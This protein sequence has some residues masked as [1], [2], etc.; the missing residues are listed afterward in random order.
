VIDTSALID[1]ERGGTEWVDRLGDLGEETVALPAIVYG[2]PM[3]G[4]TMAG[5]TRRAERR[6]AKVDALVTAVGVVPFDQE[7]AV[8]WASLFALL[9]KR[10]RMIPSNDLVVASTAR[11]LGFGVLVGTADERHFRQ[12]PKLVVRT[13]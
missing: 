11:Y 10:G 4:V 8:E 9:S 3:A 7:I 12:V 2:E 1:L 6:R 13:V 5:N